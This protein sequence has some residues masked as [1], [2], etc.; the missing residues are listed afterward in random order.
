M[1][2][3]ISELS[4][5]SHVN[6]G[7]V[8]CKLELGN[9]ILKNSKQKFQKKKFQ[10]NSRNSKKFPKIPKKKPK[11]NHKTICFL[12][13]SDLGNHIIFYSNA[14]HSFHTVI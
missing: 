7:E 1:R 12:F 9:K 14:R 5:S 8:V 6:C 2:K 4:V 13:N 11:K 3:Y 10:K